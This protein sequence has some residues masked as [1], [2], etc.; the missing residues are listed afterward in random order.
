MKRTYQAE[1]P[2][3]LEQ[4]GQLSHLKTN[5]APTYDSALCFYNPDYLGNGTMLLQVREH[6]S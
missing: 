5:T 2:G 4:G 1:L 6:R 3:E